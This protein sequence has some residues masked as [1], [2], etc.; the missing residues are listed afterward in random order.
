[1]DKYAKY[2]DAMKEAAGEQ[3]DEDNHD[4]HEDEDMHS[5]AKTEKKPKAAARCAQIGCLKNV[6]WFSLDYGVDLLETT[7]LK[8]SMPPA[9]LT[10]SK[11]WALIGTGRAQA[12]KEAGRDQSRKEGGQR[13]W[14]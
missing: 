4:G 6:L 2:Q 12:R 5:A 13:G 9:S 10:F 1:M 11:L 8:Y 7:L 3:L 14:L